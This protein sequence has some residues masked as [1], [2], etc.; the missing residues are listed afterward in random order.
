MGTKLVGYVN[1]CHAIPDHLVA[2]RAH[3]D[4]QQQSSVQH[5]RVQYPRTLIVTPHG[6]RG[7]PCRI[8]QVSR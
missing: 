6:R 5:L 4:Q 8:L 7:D 3:A 1:C 2:P